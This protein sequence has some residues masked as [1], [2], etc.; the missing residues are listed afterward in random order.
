VLVGNPVRDEVARLGDH[1]LP[2]RSTNRAA[3]DPR[4]R[5]QPGRDR[6]SAEVVP[7]GLGLLPE[8]FRRRLQVVQQCRPTISRRSRPLC[9][10]RHPGRALTYIEDMPDKLAGAPRHRPRRRL[11]HRRAD[12]RRAAG[13]PHPAADRDRRSP[14]RQ[15]ARDGQ[16]RRARG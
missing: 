16:G 3:E 5:R 6:S 12:R 7:E 14:D 8:H 9:R 10:A 4:H 15:R 1:A 11:D 13:D 2:E